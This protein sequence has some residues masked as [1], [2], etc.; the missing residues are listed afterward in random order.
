[1]DTLPLNLKTGSYHSPVSIDTKK[2]LEVY[3]ENPDNWGDLQNFQGDYIDFG[4]WKGHRFEQ[5]IT[6]IE[7]IQSSADL[8]NQV[9][10]PLDIQKEDVVLELGCGRGVGLIDV[11]LRYPCKAMIGIDLNSV[12]IERA[13]DNVGKLLGTDSNIVLLSA[14]A[15]ETTLP[16]NSVDKIFSV[17]VAQHFTSMT[18]FAC[19]VKRILR[20]DGKLAFTSYFPTDRKFYDQ[21]KGMLPLID[22]HLENTHT[23]QE[24]ADAFREAGFSNIEINSIGEHVFYGYNKWLEQCKI[25]SFSYCYYNAYKAGYIDYYTFNISI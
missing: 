24:I 8:Y 4:F 22:E 16:D 15:E 6:V 12:Q 3:G 1:M 13:R 10:N 21:L 7:R 9:V 5:K 18:N 14:V 2:L 25:N 17:E 11:F 20:P 19:E 23:A